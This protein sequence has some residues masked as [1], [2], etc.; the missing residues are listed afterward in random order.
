MI[1]TIIRVQPYIAYLRKIPRFHSIRDGTFLSKKM[2]YMSHRSDYLIHVHFFAPI[3]EGRSITMIN[4]QLT[5][6]QTFAP[7]HLR[8]YTP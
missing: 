4:S 6:I 5:Y 3:A 1:T 8:T 7:S 2:Y